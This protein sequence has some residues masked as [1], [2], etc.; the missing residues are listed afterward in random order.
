MA[1]RI[2]NVKML[3]QLLSSEIQKSEDEQNYDIVETKSFEFLFFSQFAVSAI[4][5]VTSDLDGNPINDLLNAD[6]L[7]NTSLLFPLFCTI[8]P[9]NNKTHA[10]FSYSASSIPA[11]DS[12]FKQLCS[13]N[14]DIQEVISNLAI[15]HA[16]TSLCKKKNTML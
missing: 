13:G 15:Y 7:N 6:I 14:Y 11:Y 16:E 9:Q 1:L 12:F 2:E 3:L 10:I 5:Y 8:F 4:L